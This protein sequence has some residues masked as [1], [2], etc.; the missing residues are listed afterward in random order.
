MT[1]FMTQFGVETLAGFGIGARL[2]FLMIPM[3]FG[4]GTAST[5]MIGVNFGANQNKRSY[6][7]GWTASLFSALLVGSIGAL[8]A[9]FPEIWI[10]LFTNNAD[11]QQAATSYLRIVGPFYFLFGLALCLYFSSQGAGRVLWPVLGV[12][13]RFVIIL[14]GGLL[15]VE[16]N[17][18]ELDY[19]YYLI[20]AGFIAQAITSATSVYLGAW[21]KG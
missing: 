18:M 19:F 9:I 7:I 8:F 10:N 13:F 17:F 1:S 16:Y 20:A 4:F 15:L 11:V 5:A 3:I 2:E 14:C 21:T 12:V 6:R